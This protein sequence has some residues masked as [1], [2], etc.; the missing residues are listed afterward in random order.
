MG[1]FTPGY[2]Y[3]DTVDLTLAASAARTATGNGPAVDH[4][5]AS[6][7]IVTLDVTA[8]SG[9]G[10][11]LNAKVQAQTADGSWVD[12][13]TFSQATAVGG[14][15]IAVPVTGRALR[16]AWTIGGTSPSFTFSVVAEGRR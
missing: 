9:T 8:A 14:Q 6:S 1:Y 16:A 10:P 5:G 15:T 4:E 7:A 12:V 3:V 11:T 13:A 2:R